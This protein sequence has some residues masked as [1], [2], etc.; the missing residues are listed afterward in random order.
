MS[1]LG[2][3]IVFTGT[4]TMKRVDAIKV[5][6]S[7]GAKVDSSVT[8]NTSIL[9]AGWGAGAEDEDDAKAK[10]VEIWTEDQFVAA[11]G[12]DKDKDASSAEE[13]EEA[14]T[15]KKAKHDEQI[16]VRARDGVEVTLSRDAAR[17]MGTLKDLMDLATSEDGIYPMP[18]I[19]ASTF[20]IVCKL[21]DPDYT[22]PSSD[23]HSLSQLI[24]LIEDALYLDA[25]IVLKHIQP[26]VASRLNGKS[27]PELCT[28]IGAGGDFGG[29]E[30]QVSQLFQK[31]MGAEDA[32][33]NRTPFE[34]LAD[35][36]IL[37]G[38]DGMLSDASDASHSATTMMGVVP[39]MHA[40]P[41][42]AQR[43]DE[44]RK[45]YS[46]M[47]VEE[48]R[49]VLRTLGLMTD[50]T[51]P[52]LIGRLM[53]GAAVS[54]A[55]PAFAPENFEAPQQ[56]ASSTAPPAP[57][58]QPSFSADA[59]EAAL[60][61]VDVATL[62]ELKGLGGFWRALARRVLCTRLCRRDGQPVPTQLG[63]ITDLDVEQLIEAGRPG[64]AAVA[65]RMLP[66]LARLH[67]Y[68]YVV[69]V[70]AA[71]A[72][73]LRNSLGDRTGKLS[74]TAKAVLNSCIS[75]E[76]E[77]PLRLTIAAIACAGSGVICGI[78]V[79]R[80]RE[81]SVTTL[82]LSDRGL[83]VAA[84]MLVAYLLPATSVLK[85][86]NLLKSNLGIQ[87]AMM[88]AKIGAERGIM[89][90]GIMLTDQKEADLSCQ[91]LQPAD[92]ILIA[93]DLK[94]MV[95][96]TSVDLRANSIGDD[97]A[98]AIAEALKV[99]AVLTTLNL[100][101]NSIGD[102]GAKAIAE[103][104]KVNA[105]L[106]NCNL[107]NNSLDVE[108]ATM[109]AKIGRER[110]IM[111]SG[112][113]KGD[114]TEA[115]FSGQGLQ[116]ADAILIGSDLQFMAVVT[117]LSLRNNS[118]GDKGVKAIAE[119]LKVNAVLKNC[120]L[121]NNSLDVES[122]TMLAKIGRERG[123]MLSG[124]KRDQREVSFFNEGLQPAD[125]IL[126]AS[127]LKFMA[128]LTTLNLWSNSIGDEG[129]KA[130]AEAL[131]VNAVVTTLALGNNNIGDEGAIAIAE[132][133][134]VTAVLTSLHLAA[135][136]IG[137]D[138]AKAIAEALKANAVVT[139]LNLDSNRIGDEGAIAIAEA[140]K[141][142]EMLNGLGL[143]V[144]NVGVNGAKAIAEALKVNAVL[145]ELWLGGNKIGDE[146]A[147]AI[148]DALKSG[149][150]DL[151]FLDLR[152]INIGVDGSKAIAEALKVNA[153]VTTLFLGGNNI[154]D[155]GA[156]AIAEALQV[157]AALTNLELRLSSIGDDG[158]KAIAEALK[159]NAVVTSLSLRNNS[160][161]DEG[162]KAIAEALKVNAVLKNCNLLNNSLDV[163]SATMLAKIGRERGI[164]LSGMKRDQREVSFFNEGLQPADAILIASDLKFMA[165]LTELWLGSN[166]LGL[167]G[168][169]AVRNAVK[170]GRGSRIVLHL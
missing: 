13:Q 96:L 124:M 19:M 26:A 16:R 126:I 54:I 95:V 142:D 60:G 106:K 31:I 143:G 121:L 115:D 88:L 148:A 114:K 150:A 51:K 72:A 50:G 131:K 156:I 113:K 68:G 49:L 132:A 153:V 152:N 11:V 47:R 91:D 140:L 97:G 55:E 85:N 151:T 99:N 158:A 161:G 127:D 17:L 103:A 154:G 20:Q 125:A 146:G 69:D 10:G 66:R 24:Q 76:G 1:L 67:G 141:V 23:E 147:I 123:I 39:P 22:W 9:V 25:P 134:K 102:E 136:N 117:T 77:P 168:E 101:S 135:N 33:A 83:H 4:F 29:A 75:G 38:A 73:N 27:A 84:A 90:S 98:E 166:N 40:A 45:S 12:G 43:A 2:K 105:V 64:D 32:V 122:A 74:G 62:V 170:G 71:R 94:F 63:E 6:E 82:D 162:A 41:I 86:C 5:A 44:L 21:N 149:T 36:G 144:N 100:W 57:L 116:P 139:I 58:Q 129:A 164:M 130:I 28:L 42:D 108:S 18:T 120:N 81:D 30:E 119:A 112:R 56:P 163:E 87:P 169:S 8:E 65:G 104:L 107:L 14:P 79:Q 92:A 133:L 110:G 157:T 160:I 48:L 89:L 34:M 46:R 80:M 59:T 53:A 7:A 3:T 145:T 52:V 15:A 111:L 138:G 78:P 137:V 35:S 167:A 155:E 70:A 61:L 37:L 109:L 159:V 128:V 93:S 118:I 165:V